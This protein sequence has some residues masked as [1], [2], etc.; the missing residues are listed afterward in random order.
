MDVDSAATP[1]LVDVEPDIFVEAVLDQ[2]FICGAG[3]AVV[4]CE[5]VGGW[6]SDITRYGTWRSERATRSLTLV[7]DTKNSISVEMNSTGSNEKY[8]YQCG[9][10]QYQRGNEKYQCGSHTTVSSVT[11][12][13][14]YTSLAPY[15]IPAHVNRRRRI[16]SLGLEEED[17]RGGGDGGVDV[18]EDLCLCLRLYL[19]LLLRLWWAL[20]PFASVGRRQSLLVSRFL[21]PRRPTAS[22][23]ARASASTAKQITHD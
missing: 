8:G 3:V 1:H 10:E 16:H 11:Q 17:H 9:N 22:R 13:F 12:Q 2:V 14:R 21:T 4:E 20:F 5:G 15:L 23:F 19:Q 18:C 7:L 6:L